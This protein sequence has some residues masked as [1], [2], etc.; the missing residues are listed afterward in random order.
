MKGIEEGEDK[1]GEEQK[2]GGTEEKEGEKEGL[3]ERS[4]KVE[5]KEVSKADDITVGTF[6]F[7]DKAVEST[8][9]KAKPPTTVTESEKKEDESKKDEGTKGDVNEKLVE[10]TIENAG[11][12]SANTGSGENPPPVSPCR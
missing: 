7:A 12:E 6:G 5:I 1:D 9:S 10:V 8:A 4:D 11:E 3:D 2:N